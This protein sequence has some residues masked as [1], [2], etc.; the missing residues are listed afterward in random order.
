MPVE[1]TA[2]SRLLHHFFEDAAERYP[3]RVAIDIPPGPDRANRQRTTYRELNALADSIAQRLTPFARPDGVISV[4]LDRSSHWIYAAQLAALKSGCAF[5]CI[6]EAFPDSHIRSIVSDAESSVLLTNRAGLARTTAAGIGVPY[7]VDVTSIAALVTD[8][9]R[10]ATPAHGSSRST[11]AE[12]TNLA[13]I[14]YTSGTTGTPKGVIIE[15][16]SIV[17][18]VESDL[19]E[20]QL[21]PNDRVGQGSSCAYDSSIEE[22]WLAFASGATLVVMDD[23]TSRLGPDLVP[24]LRQERITVFCPPPTLLR[25]TGCTDPAVALPDLRLLYVGGEALTDDLATLWARGRRLVNGYGPTECTVTVVRGDILAGDRVTIG[26]PV[27]GH[28]AFVVDA[29]L[30]EVVEGEAGELCI[31]GVGLARGYRNRDDLTREK[32]PAHPRLGRVYRTGDLVRRDDDGNLVYLGRIDAQV[33]LRG[34]RIELEAIEA[35][36]AQ[37]EGVRE[38]ACRV[39][40]EAGD[41]MITAHI[42]PMND[43]SPPS[44]AALKDSLRRALPHYMVPARISIISALPRSIGG[45]VDRKQLPLLDPD[46]VA[47]NRA[48]IDPRDEIET[49]IVRAFASAL[50]AAAPISVHDDFFVDLAGDSLSAV[51]VICVLRANPATEAI[52]TRDLYEARTAAALARRAAHT[53]NDHPQPPAPSRTI[54]QGHAPHPF[55]VTAMQ[56]VWILIQLLLISAAGYTITFDLLPA[57]LDRFGILGTLALEVPLA[58]AGM[59]VYTVAAVLLT[60]ILKRLLIGKYRPMTTPVWSWY[61][62]RHWIVQSVARAIPWNLLAGTAAYGAV[63]RMLGANVGKR[64][65]VHRGVNLQQGGWDLLTLGDDVT[66]SRE[67]HIGLVELDSGC[68]HVGNVEIQSQ[69]TLETRASVSANTTI[70]RGGYLAALSWLAPGQRVRAGERW[71]GVPAARSGS[72]PPSP[73]ANEIVGTQLSPIAYSALHLTLSALALAGAAIPVL[74]A[75]FTLAVCFQHSPDDIESW[76][77]QPSWS[78]EASAAVLGASVLLVPLWLVVKAMLVRLVGRVRPGVVHRWSLDYLRVWH[79]TGEVDAAGLWLSGTMFW[80]IWLRLAGMHVGRGCEISTIIDVVPET[81]RI[82]PESFFAD[83]IYLGPPLIH[84]NAVTI[85][86]TTLGRGTFLGNH[87]VIP[88]GAS[89][90]DD[91]FIGVCTIADDRRW[92]AGTSWFGNP[93]MQLPRRDVV[94]TDR[95]LTHTPGTLRYCTR[96]FW[97]SLRFTLPL[98]PLV[99]ASGWLWAMTVWQLDWWVQALVIAPIV[100]FSSLAAACLAVVALKWLLLGRAGSGQHPLWSCWCSR[101]DFLYV[102]WQFYALAPL[103]ALE[104]T[105]YLAMYLRAMGTRIGRRVVLGPGMGQLADPDMVEIE[106]DATVSANYQAHSFEDRVLK[107]APVVVCKGATVGEAAV[108]F[109]GASIGEHAWVSP[110]SVVMKNE[111]LTRGVGYSG[112][113]V[114]AIADP[115]HDSQALIM[116]RSADTTSRTPVFAATGGR[117]AFLDF[118]RGLAVI[119]MIYMHFV[120]A[121]PEASA[122]QVLS[123]WTESLS[124]LAHFCSGK[125]AAMFCILAGIAWELQARRSECSL[126]R[127]GYIARRAIALAVAGVLLHMF[128]WPTEILVPF[129]AMFVLT[130]AVRPDRSWFIFAAAAAVLLLALAVP[131]AFQD[132]ITTD[133]DYDGSHITES[134]L[135]WGTLRALT[136]DGSYPLIPWLTFPLVGVLLARLCTDLHRCKCVFSGALGVYALAQGYTF[137]AEANS[138]MLAE[139]APSLQ[140][141]WEHFTPLA[142]AVTCGS[143]AIA[144]ITGLAIWWHRPTPGTQHVPEQSIEPAPP[145]LA[146]QPRW[147]ASLSDTLGATRGVLVHAIERFGQASLTHYLLHICVFFRLLYAICSASEDPAARAPIEWS[148]TIGL[149]AF[150]VYLMVAMPLTSVWFRR[151]SR[152][153]FEAA[154]AFVSGPSSPRRN[155]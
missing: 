66:L 56:G 124:W 110:A 113:P 34:Y 35:Q 7:A 31:S 93:P 37:C 102:A 108:V 68:V 6:D 24:W 19:A 138:E 105:L 39:Q 11:E 116:R 147:R 60:V 28:A 128:A 20:F 73:P 10:Q 85:G 135:G 150:S 51:A 117:L 120:T 153:P 17:N 132:F 74:V 55:S 41:A 23:S 119:G 122:G 133:W 95:R 18:L 38:A 100:T 33:K 67:A 8:T 5:T 103:A 104:G 144:A 76:L 151:F 44:F 125:S 94:Q 148:P 62:L 77:S 25:T 59:V 13:Y 63:L 92:A 121:Q 129:A 45:K 75:L 96:L 109:Y 86:Q 50:K 111:S 98:L 81:I 80:P 46:D 118:A 106:D 123:L 36:L 27:P 126:L 61:Y 2:S 87:A 155:R 12:P 107:L 145:S 53:S 52:T 143:W 26:K 32:F 83:G 88:T 140:A 43:H 152:G 65:H 97:E 3:D 54:E 127:V 14:I 141:E 154:W 146:K 89:L 115:P 130:L 82:G 4:L 16:R 79:K 9:S 70:E 114:Q 137:W 99:I 69:A 101:W 139:S 112:C 84:R 78:V 21:L 57:L 29:D 42:V 91:L 15:H 72:A 58:L 22:T 48:I 142:F 149:L 136:F 1:R 134:E 71:A 40:G 49:I 47:P 131:L 64:V 30:N 90:P